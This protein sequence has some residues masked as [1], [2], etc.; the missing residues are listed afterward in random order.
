LGYDAK[1]VLFD[2]NFKHFDKRSPISI[3]L[4][5]TRIFIDLGEQIITDESG[6]EPIGTFNS[7]E[8]ADVWSVGVGINHHLVKAGLGLNFKDIDSNLAPR[9]P[10]GEIGEGR[11]SATMHDFGIVTYFPIS[12]IL[13]RLKNQ[14]FEILPGLSPLLGLGWGYSQSNI[15]GKISYIDA[16][17]ADPLPRTA[18]I[19]TNLHAGLAL[20]MNEQ[21]WRL[22]S[23]EH[24]HEAEQLLVR[25][26]GSRGVSYAGLLGD[27]NI[28]KNVILRQG[29]DKIITK[30]GWE[31]SLF[32]IFSLS[33]G[34]Y[35]DPLGKVFYD[36]EGWGLRLLGVLKAIRHGNPRLRNNTLFNLLARHIDV[37]YYSSRLTKGYLFAGTR[38]R[39][40]TISIF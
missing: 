28:L 7:W 33:R 4:A 13:S 21:S 29:D 40:L 31:L 8:R 17:Q 30:R 19:G 9:G 35:E 32:E 3:G 34:G 24:L 5:Y 38:F 15:G 10:G 39:G 26:D 23:F 11:A 2:Y 16:A 36:T 22:L 18:R 25:V 27:I 12:E 37:Q 20:A 1:T 14:S 6:P